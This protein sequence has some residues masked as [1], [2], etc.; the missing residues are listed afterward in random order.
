[1]FRSESHGISFDSLRKS[2]MRLFKTNVLNSV[3]HYMNLTRGLSVGKDIYEK[4]SETNKD[5]TEGV[6]AM[7]G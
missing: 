4:E 6:E 2:I 5:L 3:I 1:M 7:F